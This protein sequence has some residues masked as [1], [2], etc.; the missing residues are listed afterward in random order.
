MIESK[1]IV[2][3][4]TLRS[5]DRVE[6]VER[7]NIELDYVKIQDGLD[8]TSSIRISKPVAL[9]NKNKIM[10]LSPKKI[11]EMGKRGKNLSV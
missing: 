6:K 7:K 3:V 9:I 10:S 5:E 1:S 2:N 4:Q 8:Q 11:I